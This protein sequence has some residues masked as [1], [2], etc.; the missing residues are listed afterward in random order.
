MSIQFGP[1]LCDP[2]HDRKARVLLLLKASTIGGAGIIGLTSLDV[3]CISGIRIPHG[4][5]AAECLF[6]AV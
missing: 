1:A 5:L 4:Q 3:Y 2:A 6:P